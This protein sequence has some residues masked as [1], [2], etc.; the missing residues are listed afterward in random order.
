MITSLDNNCTVP[1][2][3]VVV[4][5]VFDNVSSGSQKVSRS[6]RNHIFATACVVREGTG[7]CEKS[8]AMVEI[9]DGPLASPSF[10]LVDAR[11]EFDTKANLLF[12]F[13]VQN[14][15]CERPSLSRIRTGSFQFFD[16]SAIRLKNTRLPKL[17]RI[18]RFKV[19]IRKKGFTGLEIITLFPSHL[20]RL[21]GTVA[22]AFVVFA[23]GENEK[24]QKY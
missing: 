6:S 21:E 20:D 8:A 24:Q 13:V 3:L 18:T 22:I 12:A 7:K 5:K 10:A 16:H 17:K 11:M 19:G 23:W 9:N 2:K 15:V 1:V 4:V 14:I